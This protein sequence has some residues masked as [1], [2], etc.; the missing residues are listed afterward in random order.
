MAEPSSVRAVSSGSPRRIRFAFL[1][2]IVLTWSISNLSSSMEL[3]FEAIFLVVLSHLSFMT[4][5]FL[6]FLLTRVSSSFTLFSKTPIVRLQQRQY[7]V[8]SSHN[9]FMSANLELL[10]PW[11]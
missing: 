1:E 9:F 2:L 5:M 3:I 8:I 6:E 4:I 7:H 10:T 11:H